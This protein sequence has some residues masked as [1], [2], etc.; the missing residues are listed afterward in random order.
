MGE[1]NIIGI[2]M[3]YVQEV[4]MLLAMSQLED[5]VNDPHASVL[6]NSIHIYT[7]VVG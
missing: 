6:K 1:A 4:M 7:L 5:L 3:I 2:E